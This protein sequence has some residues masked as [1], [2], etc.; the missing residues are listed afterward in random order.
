VKASAESVAGVVGAVSGFNSELFL[1]LFQENQNKN[2]FFS[3]FSLSSA[4]SMTVLSSFF[5]LVSFWILR[6]EFFLSS[7][8]SLFWML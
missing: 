4:L 7:L 5:P 8:L 3:P 6:F 1:R 2:I